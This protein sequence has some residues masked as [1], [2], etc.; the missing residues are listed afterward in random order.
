M[1]TVLIVLALVLAGV[2]PALAERDRAGAFDYYV[3]A[4]SW[5]PGWCDRVGRLRG[6]EQCGRGLGWSLHGLWPQYET[7]WPDY[8][9]TD[10]P[11]ATRAQTA[12]MADIMGTEGLALHQWRKHGTCSGLSAAEYFALSR[13]A[14]EVLTRPALFRAL[15]AP[16]R[17]PARLVEEAF[18]KDNPGLAPDM[19]TI[20]CRD[21][22]IQEARLCLTRTLTPRSCGADV[23]RDCTATDALLIPIR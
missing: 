4:V 9:R 18:L 7:G 23:V 13:Q 5:S 20:T 3:L 21:G 2:S 14:Y 8:C 17:L 16:V 19:L 22:Q 12:A 1:R 10:H 15:D 6:S 11:P